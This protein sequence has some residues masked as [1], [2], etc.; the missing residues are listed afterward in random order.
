MEE[1]EKI[2]KSD[3][4]GKIPMAIC[5]HKADMVSQATIKYITDKLSPKMKSFK[6]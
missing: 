3:L 6:L 1:L 2:N 5:L 4:L